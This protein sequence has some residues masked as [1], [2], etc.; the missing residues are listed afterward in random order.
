MS[1]LNRQQ[2][3]AFLGID[4]KMFDNF[5]KSAA[6]FDCLPRIGSHDRFKFD[7][8]SLRA[9]KESIKW[10]TVELTKD[11]YIQCLDFALAMHFRGY[12]RSDFS[13]GRQREFG[14]KVNNW[15]M[16]QLGE[17]GFKKFIM[18]NFAVELELDFN[19]YSEIVPQDIIGV[20]EGEVKR[21]PLIGIG[22]K[23]SKPKSAYLILDKPEV[24][25]PSRRSDIYV[26]CRVDI[27]D[28]HLLRIARDDVILAVKDSALFSEYSG[29]IPF[30]RN[31]NCEVA[32]WCRFDE[33]EEVTSIP[34]QT[35]SGPRMVKQSGK[36]RR[37]K[38]DWQELISLL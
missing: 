9:W 34:G 26:Y 24:E 29:V 18:D 2:A 37:N 33:L 12:V 28:D 21:A 17:V 31:I 8:A 4:E 6:E 32:G 19:V 5:F 35:F 11:D 15:V 20:I 16:G 25:L 3:I 1:T 23:T 36:L 7:E 22:I 27:P 14:Q 30:F 10:R 38:E 13:S